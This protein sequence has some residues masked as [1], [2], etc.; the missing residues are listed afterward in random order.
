VNLNTVPAQG[1]GACDQGRL[2]DQLIPFLCVR[3]GVVGVNPLA[4]LEPCPLW[5]LVAEEFTA[6][7][8]ADYFAAR[9][10]LYLPVTSQ[11]ML[12]IAGPMRAVFLRRDRVLVQAVFPVLFVVITVH[13]NT[14]PS[15][16]ACRQ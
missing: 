15:D 1:L 9:T 11:M 10:A 4:S 13:A 5:H 16:C 2:I 14:T 6:I 12:A 7:T 3:A 8:T